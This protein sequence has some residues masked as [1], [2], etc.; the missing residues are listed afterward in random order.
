[1]ITLAPEMKWLVPFWP[2][3]CFF[4]EWS[5]V[6]CPNTGLEIEWLVPFLPFQFSG[7]VLNTGPIHFRTPSGGH[8]GLSVFIFKRVAFKL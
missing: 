2:P 3:S 7:H 4:Y 6:L 8:Q 5:S 1:M